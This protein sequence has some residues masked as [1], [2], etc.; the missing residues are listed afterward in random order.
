[1]FFFFFFKLANVQTSGWGNVKLLSPVGRSADLGVP[2]CQQNRFGK[3]PSCLENG[4]S[5]GRRK[6]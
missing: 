5:E 2:R 3:A 4:F 6:E 1:M